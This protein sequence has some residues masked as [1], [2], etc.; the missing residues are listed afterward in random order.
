MRGEY[1]VGAPLDW[2]SGA[3][4][5]AVLIPSMP[6]DSSS[7]C[8]A[9]D[10]FLNAASLIRP[11]IIFPLLFHFP[12]SLVHATIFPPFKTPFDAKYFYAGVRSDSV[13]RDGGSTLLGHRFMSLVPIE[14]EPTVSETRSC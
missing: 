12:H 6:P 7:L 3:F 1:V 11:R 2:G 14:C 13:C 10:L 8:L 9:L 5:T 4:P